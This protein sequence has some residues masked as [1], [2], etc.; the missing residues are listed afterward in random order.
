MYEAAAIALNHNNPPVAL[1]EVNCDEEKEMC[2]EA[3]VTGFP[4]LKVYYNGVF[5]ED[6]DDQRTVDGIVS[7]MKARAG[8]ASQEFDTND[9]LQ[10]MIDGDQIVIALQTSS[11]DSEEQFLKVAK[12]MRSQL[13]FAHTTSKVLD[14][15]KET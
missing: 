3:G 2:N 14:A 10:K 15:S 5:G 12:K 11:K 13:K 9:E 8:P 7:F 4:T 1:L 6:F